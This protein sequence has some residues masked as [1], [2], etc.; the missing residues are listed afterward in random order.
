MPLPA[1]GTDAASVLRELD[2]M[3]ERDVRWRDGHAFTL[4][5]YAGA[6]AQSAKL[7]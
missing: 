1:E 5:Y 4:T 3:K 2:S 6:E 7:V